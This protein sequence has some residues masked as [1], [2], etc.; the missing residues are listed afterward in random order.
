MRERSTNSMAEAA[1][2]GVGLGAVLMGVLFL[3][4]AL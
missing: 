2:V 4:A 3:L 1:S